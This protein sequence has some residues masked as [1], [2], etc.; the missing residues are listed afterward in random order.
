MCL[1]LGVLGENERVYLAP[2]H[3]TIGL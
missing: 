2:E 1:A 3:Q